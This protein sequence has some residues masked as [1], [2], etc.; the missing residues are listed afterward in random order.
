M[1]PQA[2]PRYLLTSNAG[3]STGS[4]IPASSY[5]F[6]QPQKD[7][8][9]SQPH[10]VLI[11]QPRRL[12]RQNQHSAQS[13]VPMEGWMLMSRRDSLILAVIF[14]SLLAVS[15][16]SIDVWVGSGE[17]WIH[18]IMGCGTAGTCAGGRKSESSGSWCFQSCSTDVRLGL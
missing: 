10:L 13:M 11:Q 6:C 4:I 2:R 16:R 8:R 15:Q 9:L 14:K 17:S 3:Y 12:L 7:D 18:W 5:S 1:M